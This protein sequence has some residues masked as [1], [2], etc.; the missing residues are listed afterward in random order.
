MASG[1]QRHRNPDALASGRVEDVNPL[2]SLDP[3]RGPTPYAALEP[4]PSVQPALLYIL[5]TANGVLRGQH[6]TH[7]AGP[8]TPSTSTQALQA[9]RGH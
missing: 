4:L 5:T 3:F 8:R 2:P 7:S 9:R 6:T 1:Q